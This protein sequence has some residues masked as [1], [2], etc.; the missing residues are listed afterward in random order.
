MKRKKPMP[1]YYG[2]NIA[3]HAQ[4][5]FFQRKALEADQEKRRERDDLRAER[6]LYEAEKRSDEYESGERDHL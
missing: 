4:R 3:Q 6:A 1:G 2:K 5:R